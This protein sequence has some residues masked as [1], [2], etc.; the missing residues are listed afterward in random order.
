M[1]EEHD[2]PAAKPGAAQASPGAG[3]AREAPAGDD[4]TTDER[5]LLD[6]FED[7]QRC[8]ESADKHLRFTDSYGLVLMLLVT[9][10]FVTAIGGEHTWGRCLSLAMLGTTTWLALRASRVERLLL[11]WATAL[12]P[13]ATVAAVIALLLGSAETGRGIGAALTIMLVVVAP[14]AIVKRLASHLVVSLNTFYGAVCVYLLLAMFFASLYALTSVLTGESFFAQIVPPAKATTIDYLYFSFIT[15]TTVGYGDL[16]AAGN[17][18]RM[19]ASIEAVLGQLYLITVVALV[20][21]NLGQERRFKNIRDR[22]K[23]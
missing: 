21:Q 15:I 12:I 5:K 9:T 3:T 10:F 8:E 19:L 17:V 18:G 7:A 4:L 20:V 14:V 22:L 16:T 2:T 13:I 23:K 1:G 6:E 11:R